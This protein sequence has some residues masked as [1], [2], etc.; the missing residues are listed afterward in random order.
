M[1]GSFR[2]FE[3]LGR[4]DTPT[5][6]VIKEWTVKRASA[7]SLNGRGL[8]HSHAVQ[9]L[10]RL[11][12]LLKQEF[13]VPR[14]RIASVPVLL[15]ALFA[16]T[17]KVEA[18][19]SV[20]YPAGPGPKGIAFDGTN[21]WVTNSGF[22]RSV[23]K[24]LASTGAIVGTYQVGTAPEGIAFDGTNIWVANL[25][26][27][28]VTKLRAS[29]GAEVGVFRVN[30]D[31]EAV[32]FDGNNIWVTSSGGG[33]TTVV[34]VLAS[35]GAIVGTYQVGLNP[36]ALAFDGTNIW[37]VNA[38]SNSV[39]KML[40]A[41]GAVVGTY[42]VG[43]NPR[44]IAFDG[45]NIWV[46]NQDSNSV[47]KLVASTGAAVGTYNVGP[48]PDGIVF[49]GA[50]IWV[51]NYGGNSV[52]KLLASSGATVG[53]Y[54]VGSFPTGGVAFD[55]SNVWVTNYGSNSV[56]KINPTGQNTATLSAA[57]LTFGS[58]SVGRT[59]APQTVSLTNSGTAALNISG[60][61]ITGLQSADFAQ[62]NNCGSLVG[63]GST[64]TISVTF[65][66]TATG[67]RVATITITDNASNSP[68]TIGLSGIAQLTPQTITFGPLSNLTYPVAPF[69]LSATASSGLAVSLASSTP[70]VCT[71][72]GATVT[73]RGVGTCSIIASQPGNT[74]YSPAASITQ[75][76]SVTL[77]ADQGPSILPAGIVPLYSTASTIQP[78]EWVSIF[79]ANLASGTAVW[80]G[81][82]PTSL[83]GTTVKINGKAAYLSLVSPGQINLQA[84]DDSTTGT[85]SVIVTTA[86]G[87]AT[88]TVT[89]GRFG[90]SFA[91]LD[92]KH[93][94]GIILR[95]DG[96]GSY[97]GGTYDIL[98]PTGS[99]L[100]YP[101]VA[102][103]AGDIV[104]LFGVGL[105][106]TNP[107]VPAG[108]PF[109]GAAI[110]VNSVQ[111]SIGS[112]TMTPSFAGLSSAGLYQINLTMPAGLGTG[113][114]TLRATVGGV[115]TQSGTVISV[116]GAQ[117]TGFTG[118]WSFTAKSRVYGFQSGASGQLTQSGNTISGQ[119]ILNGTPCATSAA[120]SGT[121]SGNSLSMNL[122]ENG[123]IVLFSGSVSSDGNSASGTY[124]A[125]P[126][127]CTN[128]DSG[129]WVGT[130]Q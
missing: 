128:G 67:A 120:V 115:Q 97:G 15:L 114:Q 45:A 31:P 85:V 79:G 2:M 88:S 14:A 122:D 106:P 117:P 119:L 22:N 87:S 93:V 51:V 98:G 91:L 127:G 109:S 6:T 49:D 32:V 52:T 43:N 5:G 112:T 124:T 58:Q 70:T 44:A 55:G 77:P 107:V 74:I 63:P 108:Q 59:S 90:P 4:S 125:P 75:S 94:A 129:T 99:S 102:A 71:V 104:E 17:G 113:D 47:T 76:F 116:V 48:S 13:Q 1:G 46:T 73:I 95:S 27:Q 33:G 34:K 19:T 83:G 28:T 30:V 36:W 105:G 3:R 38:G 65:T 118:Y 96:S 57:N 110:T 56:T 39:T 80:N 23:T 10:L 123:Q 82:F 9:T 40:A 50:N 16:F 8:T 92:T 35:T 61:S 68:Q 126:G 62:A 66:P 89:L 64:C 21:I 29:T 53:T 12:R 86:N 101:T 18:Q 130:R 20:N 100:G 84:P 25:G 121:V 24:L 111:L 37:V 26:D 11:L 60:I 54:P 78:G 72:S 81:D 41:T 69:T 42:T 7:I 103:R